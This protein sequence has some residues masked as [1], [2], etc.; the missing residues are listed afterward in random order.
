MIENVIHLSKSKYCR[1][2]QCKK[3][4]W[5]DKYREEEKIIKASENILNNG[6]KVGELARGLF[7]NY[8][9]IPYNK[10]LSKMIEDTKY[11]IENKVNI[12][13]EASFNYNNNFC[14]VDILKNNQ[15][16]LEIYEVKSSTHIDEIYIDDASYQYYVLS[17]LG[18]NVKK[19]SIVYV[20]NQYIRHG[21]LE[22]NK[23]FNIEDITEIAK[24]KYDEIK[25]NI[26][27]INLYMNTYKE[28]NEPQE[29]IGMQCTKPYPCE[30]W[31]YCTKN[32]PKPNVFDIYG[33]MRT[34]KKFEKYYEGKI[35]FKDLQYENLNPKYLEQID[36]EINNKEPKIEKEP[37]KELLNSLK[38][39]LYFIDFET[40]QLAIPEYDGTK[41]Y[42]QLPFQYSLHIIEKEGAPIQ[43][44]E[45]LAEIDDKDF[46]RHFAESMIKDIPQNGSVIVYNMSF[47]HSRINELG[48]IFPDLKQE[49]M[50]INNN[51]VDF[52]PPFKNRHYYMKEMEGSASIKKVLPALY[53]D[54]PE[55]NYHNLPVVHN[56]EEASAT[57]LSLQGK[58]KQEQEELRKGLLV[59]C[60]LDTYAMVKIW[61]KL[62]KVVKENNNG[63]I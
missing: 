30:Y 53:P 54:A 21:E 36:F 25:E 48:E 12:I 49:L 52:L 56:G 51:M 18:Y 7:G 47:E 20:N 2:I 35:S 1:A 45:F 59:Y 9:N 16:S 28:N 10:D 11:A 19:V 38:Y 63:I 32:L 6:T 23:L 58:S 42:Q 50:R 15:E 26:G 13:T 46:L 31:E 5:L 44:K 17:S 39:P 4:L 41:P 22:L 62:K 33:G 43:H 61:E 60:E 29:L 40:I 27:Q 3:I 57:F 55:L 8:T 37:I 34:D 24:D 14:S